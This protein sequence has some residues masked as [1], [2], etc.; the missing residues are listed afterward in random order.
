[1]TATKY[2]LFA[3][4]ASMLN[5][6]SQYLT[7]GVYSGFAALYVAMAVGTL[8]GLVSKY[9]LDKHYIFY[10]STESRADDARNFALYSLTGVLTTAVFWITEIAF[11][12]VFASDSAKYVGGA[13]G[14]AIGYTVKYFLDRRYVFRETAV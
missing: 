13:I 7:L 12:A 9:L 11:D 3:C 8:V 4:A 5:L 2:V 14:L 10:H 1:M 6:L